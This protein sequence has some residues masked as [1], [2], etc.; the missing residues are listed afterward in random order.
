VV[1]NSRRS[2]FHKRVRSE[3]TQSFS[4]SIHATTMISFTKHAF[5]FQ[6]AHSL[7]N[8][9]LAP[10]TPLQCQR[11]THCKEVTYLELLFLYELLFNRDSKGLGHIP[12]NEM[13]R[14]ERAPYQTHL[15]SLQVASTILKHHSGDCNFIA[16]V[17]YG[18][19]TCGF[20]TRNP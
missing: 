18:C 17:I 12:V 9:I 16:T 5:W 19:V 20:Y 7:P 14:P 15:I 10:C 11:D 4:E 6:G 13:M 8:N 2:Q 1:C 3:S